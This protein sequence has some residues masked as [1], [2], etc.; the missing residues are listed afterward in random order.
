[1][2]HG[3]VNGAGNDLHGCI[4]SAPSFDVLEIV[5]TIHQQSLVQTDSQLP[6]NTFILESKCDSTFLLWAIQNEQL[7]SA[8]SRLLSRD[9]SKFVEVRLNPRS[10]LLTVKGD[11]SYFLEYPRKLLAID[12]NSGKL[13]WSSEIEKLTSVSLSE[14]SVIATST[15]GKL[16]SLDA[17]TGKFQWSYQLDYD[18]GFPLC[19]KQ[20]IFRAHDQRLI[21]FL[22]KARR[23]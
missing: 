17:N 5:P 14:S 4:A 6:N 2:N 19:D 1:M 11:R 12:L 7:V 8:Q 20:S 16:T 9:G 18:L 21:H 22:N 10:I 13:L 15:N 3:F 23:D